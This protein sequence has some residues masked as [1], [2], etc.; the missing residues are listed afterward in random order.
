M[1]IDTHVH[2]YP[3]KIS[4]KAVAHIGEFYK[5]TMQSDDGCIDEYLR[6]AKLTQTSVALITSV[7]TTPMQVGRIN[8][9]LLR[10][11]EEAKEIEGN[12][13]VMY[14]LATLHPDLSDEELKFELKVTKENGFIGYKL[15]PD[16]QEFALDGERAFRIFE[17]LDGTMPVLVH[18]GDNRKSFSNPKRVAALAKAFPH[19]TIIAAHMGGWSEWD[20]VGVYD[21]LSNV[22][23]DTCSTLG[24]ITPERALGIIKHF[25][26][27]R[28]LY[29][30]DFPM[31]NLKEEIERFNKLPLT[32]TE[33]TLILSENAK[34][35]YRLQ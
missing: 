17:G 31:W 3:P 28:F 29:G 2:V 32:E 9:F 4:K 6:Q 14:P 12:N 27:E 30:T 13:C 15:H 35:L 8:S 16:F 25:G 22:M 26:A 18:A 21:N 33:K 34:K 7:A 1:I 23:F 20:D 10:T 19:I 5:L 24:F 11:I